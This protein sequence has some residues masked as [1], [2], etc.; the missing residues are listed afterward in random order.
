[1]TAGWYRRAQDESWDPLADAVDSVL[2]DYP[3]P[4]PRKGKFVPKPTQDQ[5]DKAFARAVEQGAK[6]IAFDG[7][8]EVDRFRPPKQ[9]YKEG[10]RDWYWD[11]NV[12]LIL[13]NTSEPNRYRW[14]LKKKGT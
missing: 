9:G 12:F 3:A 7:P 5:L 2:P 1:M 13:Y 6:I 8:F 4:T 11:E 14:C 10:D